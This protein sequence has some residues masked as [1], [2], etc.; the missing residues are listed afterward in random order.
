MS[1]G[2]A[3]IVGVALFVAVIFDGYIRLMLDADLMMSNARNTEACKELTTELKE[4]QE[5]RWQ[6]SKKHM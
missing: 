3:V 4:L 5:A 2:R 6:H 1:R